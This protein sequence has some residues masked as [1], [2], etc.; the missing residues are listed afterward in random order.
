M[1]WLA[2]VVFKIHFYIASLHF[3][4]HIFTTEFVHNI[5]VSGDPAQ[6]SWC[7]FQIPSSVTAS[8]AGRDDAAL[9]PGSLPG[10]EAAALPGL[11]CALTVNYTSVG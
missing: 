7:L 5:D 8:E 4:F 11:S 3:L 10:P 6:A 2:L 1:G 9:H